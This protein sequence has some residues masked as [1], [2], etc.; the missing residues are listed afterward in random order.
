MDLE[1]FSFGHALEYTPYVVKRFLDFTQNNGP[2]RFKGLHIINQ[3]RIFQPILGA[4]KPF[5]SP[6]LAER[7][8]AHGTNYESLHRH[9]APECLP[10]C[11]GGTL[12]SKLMYGRETYELLAKHEKFFEDLQKYGLKTLG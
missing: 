9:I 2:L 7:I 10:K 3:P 1:D 5:F 4:I 11:Y 8:I 6:K 12:D